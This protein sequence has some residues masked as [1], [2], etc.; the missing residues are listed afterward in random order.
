MLK[1]KY[2]IDYDSSK[3]ILKRMNIPWRTIS[4]SAK[5]ISQEKYKKTCLEKY[6]V[7]NVSKSEDIKKKKADTFT[8]HYGV[9][10]IWKTAGY[11]KKMAE[12]H[13]DSHQEHMK[14]LQEGC[15]KFWDNL[16]EDGLCD[17]VQKTTNGRSENY[18]HSSLEIR[19]CSLLEQL[20]ISYTRQFHINKNRHPYD[21]HLCDS[22]IVIEIN[23]NFWHANPLYY[24]EDDIVNLPGQK[25]KAKEVWNRDKKFTDFAENNGYKV[26]TIWEDEFKKTDEELIEYFLNLLKSV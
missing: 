9:D 18:Y 2:D 7:D 3:Y 10:N 22:K 24:N 21:F 8:E 1:E 12:L 11:N 16:T 17:W 6:G 5:Q 23:G 19:F 15:Q 25:L 20:N 4:E 26:I 13:P 14:K